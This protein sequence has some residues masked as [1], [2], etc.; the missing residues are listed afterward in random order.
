MKN[1]NLFALEGDTSVSD[2]DV[3]QTL[4]LDIDLAGKPEINDAAIAS[5][6]KQNVKAFM[7][8]GMPEGEAIAQANTLAD[9]TRK[10]IQAASQQ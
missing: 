9:Q 7:R 2:V 5:M 10:R 4:G 3:C 1:Y 6:H 8:D